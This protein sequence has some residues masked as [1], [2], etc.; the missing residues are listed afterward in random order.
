MGRKWFS[1]Y[2]LN[3]NHIAL[4]YFLIDKYTYNPSNDI[5]YSITMKYHISLQIVILQK[6]GLS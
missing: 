5:R 2:N 3:K 4:K 1:P 6:R